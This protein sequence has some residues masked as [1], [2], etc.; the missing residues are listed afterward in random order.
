MPKDSG[1]PDVGDL[2]M[3]M[4]PAIALPTHGEDEVWLVIETRS[5][6]LLVIKDG[7]KDW[8]RR[9]SVVVVG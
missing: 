1:V 8:V 5:V 4:A 6:H 9:A 2:V 3:L 7:V